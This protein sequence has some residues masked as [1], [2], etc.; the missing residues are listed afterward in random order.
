MPGRGRVRQMR[1]CD[2]RIHAVG[3]ADAS[4][5][6][7]AN[8]HCGAHEARAPDSRL[9]GARRLR[10]SAVRRCYKERGVV[11]KAPGGTRPTA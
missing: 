3:D 9:P 8:R 4:R 10:L 7:R 1:D 2:G 11:N 5:S 6:Q